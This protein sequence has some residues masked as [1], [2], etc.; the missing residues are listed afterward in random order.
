LKYAAEIEIHPNGKFLYV[1]NRG[2]GAI[3]VFKILEDG[4][5]RFVQV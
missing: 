4:N 5:L 3:V 1:S 2:T